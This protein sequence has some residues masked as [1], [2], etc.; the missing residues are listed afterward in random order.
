MKLW[1]AWV[2]Y[3]ATGEGRT[4][5]ALIMYGDDEAEIR[6]KF[7][8]LFGQYYSLGMEVAEGI[9]RND[10]VN[11]V[12]SEKTLLTA[13]AVARGANMSLFGQVHFNLS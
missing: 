3:F 12:F 10:V 9:V 1:T 11:S 6:S 2:D 4:M 5:C 7:K 13:N 8:N